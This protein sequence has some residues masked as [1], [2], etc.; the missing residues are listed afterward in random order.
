MKIQKYLYIPWL[1]G[2]VLKYVFSKLSKLFQDILAHS[3]SEMV[4]EEEE[5]PGAQ[6]RTIPIPYDHVRLINSLVR[7]LYNTLRN[8]VWIKGY[9]SYDMNIMDV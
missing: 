6:S 3:V 9:G 4:L 1:F 5:T 7:A 2:N 8:A